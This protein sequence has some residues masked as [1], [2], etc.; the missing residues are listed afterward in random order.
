MN[1]KI[2]VKILLFATLAKKIT[3]EALDSLH[4]FDN[5]N[6]LDFDLKLI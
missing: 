6:L 4:L 2:I 1:I 5:I 3:P